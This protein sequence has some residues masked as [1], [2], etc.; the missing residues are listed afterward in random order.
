MEAAD[1]LLNNDKPVNHNNLEEDQLFLK[2]KPPGVKCDIVNECKVFIKAEDGSG[3]AK[4]NITNA[5]MPEK[6]GNY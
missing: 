6:S 1:R 3:D 4:L 2:Q 5:M